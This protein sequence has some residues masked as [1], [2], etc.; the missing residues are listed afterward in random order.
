[1][2]R[3]L[4]SLLLLSTLLSCSSNDRQQP[5]GKTKDSTSQNATD[6]GSKASV[7]GEYFQI[8]RD[9][10]TILPFEIG[11]SL[12]AKAQEKL[13]RGHETIIV[14]VFLTGKP[15]DSSAVTLSEDGSFN[16]AS[17]QKEISYGQTA[18]FDGIKF[19]K[20]IYDELAD[21]DIDLGVNVY[22]G[23][24]TF[25]DNILDCDDL[26]DK[27]SHV[28]NRKFILKGKLIYGDR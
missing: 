12:S 27:I 1:M 7:A 10:I 24:R 16:V 14:S 18:R 15:K 9:S 5:A 11:I 6:T 2:T 22:S 26:F 23:R 17:A 4:T 8:G 21:K 20:K 3:Q 28:V 13:K 19:P 25:R